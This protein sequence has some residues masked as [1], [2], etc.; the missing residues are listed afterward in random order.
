MWDAGCQVGGLEGHDLSHALIYLLLALFQFDNFSYSLIL[1][2]SRSVFSLAYFSLMSRHSVTLSLHL[3]AAVYASVSC[4]G[5]SECFEGIAWPGYKS[6]ISGS[7]VSAACRSWRRCTTAP[8][9]KTVTV[10]PRS[11]GGLWTPPPVLHLSS[12]SLPPTPNPATTTPRSCLRALVWNMATVDST[13]G[14]SCQ[15]PR[16]WSTVRRQRCFSSGKAHTGVIP[17]R[18]RHRG[19]EME[20]RV[21]R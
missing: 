17:S 9:V 16:P 15:T 5:G 8:R 6:V 12:T 21:A 14:R 20:R 18:S 4:L 1:P 11:P 7:S 10:P 13:T 3:T 19:F 2:S